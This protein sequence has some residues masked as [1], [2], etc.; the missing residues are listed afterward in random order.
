MKQAIQPT[1]MK[2]QCIIVFVTISLCFFSL[3]ARTQ[4]KQIIKKIEQLEFDWH[5]AWVKHDIR[6]IEN[7][8]ADDFKNVGRTGGFMNRQQTL[9]NFRSDSSVY[10]YC[11]VY[12]PEYR[13]YK[14]AV[15]VLCKTKEK[16]TGADNKPFAATYFSVDT[17]IKRK[18]KWQCVQANVSKIA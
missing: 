17:F 1:Y 7:V 2:G 16:G 5:N 14:K 4:N 11:T 18:G 13:V 6:L 9:E 8:L 3:S 10:E 12:D 15:I